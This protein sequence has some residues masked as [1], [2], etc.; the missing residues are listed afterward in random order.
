MRDL[1][2]K[3]NI[4]IKFKHMYGVAVC[5]QKKNNNNNNNKLNNAYG[6]VKQFKPQIIW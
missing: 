1:E 4:K 3:S 2:Q 5:V 6:Q